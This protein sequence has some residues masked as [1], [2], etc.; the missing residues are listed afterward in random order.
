MT[1][2]KATGAKLVYHLL[3]WAGVAALWFYLRYQDYATLLQAALVT[4]IKVVDLAVVIYAANVVLVPRYL[5]RKKYLR[6]ALFFV[7][8]VGFFS[9]LKMLAVTAVLNRSLAETNVKEA[10]YNNFVTQFF[11]VLASIAL[12]S[13]VDYIQ[14][15]K[16]LADVARE[17]AEAELAFLKAQINPHFL[18]NSLNAVYFLIDKKNTQARE[19]LHTF[20]EM[21]RYQL[22]EC[23]GQ[24]IP[25]EKEIGFL[26]D[27]VGLQRLRM[28]ANTQVQ[29]SCATNVAQFSIEPLLLIPFVENSFKHL[30]HFGEGRKNEVR[31]NLSR[32]NGT[33]C[34]QVHNTTE[35]KRE[36]QPDG[37]IGLANVQKRLHLLY[38]GKHRLRLTEE[39][40]W[41]GVDL[42]LNLNA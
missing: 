6:F 23:N 41:F 37:G 30:S 12:R 13:A 42:Q 24:R 25:I 4:V 20:S 9:F 14:L 38:P 5:Y 3:F 32:Q 21:L 28:A 35:S 7:M 11:L 1:T 19:A 29:F 27:Y 22:Y 33:V 17:K 36:P 26:N 8:L 10:V 39:D 34:F 40:G 16:R 2:Q 15:Q 18:F 31:I